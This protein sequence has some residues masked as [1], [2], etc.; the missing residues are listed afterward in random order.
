M[1]WFIEY[2]L[3]C[4]V[5]ALVC[6]LLV[7]FKGVQNTLCAVYSEIFVRFLKVCADYIRPTIL[8][9]VQLTCPL[10]MKF[11]N[12]II[13]KLKLNLIRSLFQSIV[14]QMNFDYFQILC[15]LYGITIVEVV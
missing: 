8:T 11:A 13:T 1:W 2:L 4:T 10:D 7:T 9:E 6:S 15:S 12:R 5:N 3:C 14:W